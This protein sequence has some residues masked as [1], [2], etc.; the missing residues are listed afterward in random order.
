MLYIN[1][2]E[3]ASTDLH[4]LSSITQQPVDRDI[5]FWNEFLGH[6]WEHVSN[7][8]LSYPL[9]HDSTRIDFYCA[10]VLTLRIKS[11]PNYWTAAK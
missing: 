3:L 5:G 10:F 8:P 9:H 7:L 1:Q 11:Y 6:I 4:R 2:L